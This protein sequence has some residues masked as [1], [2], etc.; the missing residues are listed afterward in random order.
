MLASKNVEAQ[1]TGA[2]ARA[3]MFQE[4]VGASPLGQHRDEPHMGSPGSSVNT[5][6]NIFYSR[7]DRIAN[8]AA[9]KDDEA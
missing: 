3:K 9:S 8:D 2:G 4:A 5:R 6:I 7:V 1:P